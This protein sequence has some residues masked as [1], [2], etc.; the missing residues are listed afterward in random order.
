MYCGHEYSVANLKY[1]LHVESDNAAAAEKL[2]W[3]IEQRSKNLRTIPSTIGA[4]MQFNPFM[5]VDLDKIKKRYDQTDAILCMQSMR[6]EK[7]GW[8]PT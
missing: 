8:K 5:R 3:A 6:K 7:D 1:A 2:A 4:E